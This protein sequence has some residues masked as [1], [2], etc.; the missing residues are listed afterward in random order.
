MLNQK[1]GNGHEQHVADRLG[2]RRS[3]GSGNQWRDPIDAR[4]NRLDTEYAFAA[5]AKS[6]LAKSLS[7]SL[8][9]WHK[10][11]EQAGGERPM[12]ALR[13]YT[14]RTLA[15]VHADLAVSL[16]DDFAD[17]LGAARLWE[18]AQPILK[19]LVHPDTADTEW[20]DVVIAEAN[21]LL[22]EAQKGW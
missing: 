14:D 8:A 2:M 20:L 18:A 9:M 10:A 12:L 13:F 22:E 4:H 11:V 6:T 16:L 5:D 1:M 15:D 19:R 3:R 7:V 21:T 17:L